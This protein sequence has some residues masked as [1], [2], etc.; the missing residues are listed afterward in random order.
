MFEDVK[1]IY[2]LIGALLSALAV[3]GIDPDKLYTSFTLIYSTTWNW[4]A[5]CFPQTLACL[6]F[7]MF[8][9]KRGKNFAMTPV[10]VNQNF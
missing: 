5:S 8:K 1:N 9:I 2:C 3:Q 4:W 10:Y 7:E 6:Q